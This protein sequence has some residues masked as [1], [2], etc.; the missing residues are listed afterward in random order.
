MSQERRDERGINSTGNDQ[1]ESDTQRIIHRHL[2]NKDDII[3]E[4][5]IR[6][7]R[8]GMVPPET[9]STDSEREEEIEDQVVP[10]NNSENKEPN[11]EPLTPYD[12]TDQ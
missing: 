8:V 10:V 9:L 4:E 12:M 5:D 1:F 11:D 7:V 3:S 6:N 2:E